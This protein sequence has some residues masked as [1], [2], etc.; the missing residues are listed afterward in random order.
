MNK[1]LLLFVLALTCVS[2][3]AQHTVYCEIMQFSPGGLKSMISVDFGNN[4]T[5]EIV[6]TDGKKIKFKSSIATQ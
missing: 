1:M 3:R 2:V 5:D 4:G 6:D